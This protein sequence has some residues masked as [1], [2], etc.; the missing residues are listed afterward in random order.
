M[1][2]YSKF[3]STARK[4][5][6]SWWQVIP[7]FFGRGNILRKTGQLFVVLKN[8][9]HHDFLKM[10]FFTLVVNYSLTAVKFYQYWGLFSFT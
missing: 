7:T 5:I 3:T 8:L 6:N 4:L 9:N 10:A 2:L 1:A